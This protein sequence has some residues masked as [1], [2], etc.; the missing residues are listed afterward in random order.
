MRNWQVLITGGSSGIGLATARVL[1][2]QGATVH[3]TGRNADQLETARK[4]LGEG[5]FTYQGDISAHADQ[6]RLLESLE[7]RTAGR[8]DGA[9]INAAKYGFE[10]LMALT[11][12]ELEDYFRTNCI[13]PVWLVQGL[14]PLMDKGE[15]K[16]I[17]MI[18]ST[19][20]TKPIAGTA[21]YAASKAALNSLTKSF[22]I[23]LAADGIRCNAILPGVVDTPI[24]EPQKEGDIPRAE[25][26]A[27]L[28]PVHLLGRVGKPE[29]VADM[30]SFLL[31]KK[32]GWVTGGLFPVDGGI[33]LA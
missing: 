5:V 17:V 32:A 14:K 20:S 27:Q 7:K 28:G 31:S 13:S 1:I 18:S 15:G 2:E 4:T 26:M 33:S 25:K 19:L 22:A 16:S 24:H 29:E 8:I 3:I 21:A 10:P 6:L 9:V 23:E 11:P 30:A 12:P